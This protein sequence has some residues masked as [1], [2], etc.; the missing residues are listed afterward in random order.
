[1]LMVDEGE[2]DGL[3][4]VVKRFKTDQDLDEELMDETKVDSPNP[5]PPHIHC[6]HRGTSL[7]IPPPPRRTLH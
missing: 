1:M 3:M 6:T 2:R 5:K 7:I 4:Y